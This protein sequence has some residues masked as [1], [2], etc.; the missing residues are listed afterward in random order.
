MDIQYYKLI[1]W[2]NKR[3]T[4]E[5]IFLIL[6]L[7]G[8]TY[9]IWNLLINHALLQHQNTQKQ[10]IDATTLEINSTHTQ[11]KNALEIVTNSSYIQKLQQQKLLTAQSQNF[12]QH[13][14]NLIPTAIAP[15]DLPALT[16]AILKLNGIT[17]VE[18]KELPSEK[19]IPEG[20]NSLT[21]PTNTKSIYKYQMAIE[22]YSDFFGTLDYLSR[23]EKLPWHIYW[24]SVEYTVIQYPKADVK[25]KIYV[26]TTQAS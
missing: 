15:K 2:F 16:T 8:L 25:I 19:W 23:L 13:L 1:D 6:V 24:D 14:E 21:L 4:R 5:R 7:C 26:L 22:F 17:L 3:D 9:I 10:E 20:L 18:L 12:E 11:L